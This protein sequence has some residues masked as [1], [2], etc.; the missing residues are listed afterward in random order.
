MGIVPDQAWYV[1]RVL[2]EVGDLW[3]WL[4]LHLR[5]AAHQTKLL[6]YLGKEW[7]SESW[8]WLW[9]EAGRINVSHYCIRTSNIAEEENRQV[10]GT[11]G[12]IL[13]GRACSD[14]VVVIKAEIGLPS[15]P[16]SVQRS[17]VMGRAVRIAHVMGG[18][19]NMRL[20]R[21]VFISPMRVKLAEIFAS[22]YNVLDVES[23]IGQHYDIANADTRAR[24]S[25]AVAV[26]APPDD[27]GGIRCG[28]YRVSIFHSHE[29]KETDSFFC[30]HL[31]AARRKHLELGRT[32]CWRDNELAPYFTD[33]ALVGE[34]LS[35]TDLFAQA[36]ADVVPATA[37]DINV[38]VQAQISVLNSKYTAVTSAMTQLSLS[39]QRLSLLTAHATL[40]ARIARAAHSR[41]LAHLTTLLAGIEKRAL[42]LAGV[43]RV[44]ATGAQTAPRSARSADDI[45]NQRRTPLA[46][47]GT[48]LSAGAASMLIATSGDASSGTACPPSS[49][50]RKR[51]RVGFPPAQVNTFA[52]VLATEVDSDELHEYRTALD[53]KRATIRQLRKEIAQLQQ[54]LEKLRTESDARMSDARDEGYIAGTAQTYRDCEA[55][56]R[57]VASSWYHKPAE[58]PIRKALLTLA[59]GFHKLSVT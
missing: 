10:K 12:P 18:Q 27:V 17:Y 50:T 42:E 15:D 38:Q 3:H 25:A 23:S 33:P 36:S 16:D 39:A 43:H 8:K 51:P 24:L 14:P 58:Q 4:C 11:G 41:G 32:R 2:K 46:F 30:K 52:A 1:C 37:E 35:V 54:Q 45:A 59:S 13:D 56:T 57:E 49:V 7:M 28:Y 31:L 20:P 47:T 55:R 9:M 48:V 34:G 19:T 22:P 5:I 21:R 44:S 40:E 6:A 29:C 53:A 26:A